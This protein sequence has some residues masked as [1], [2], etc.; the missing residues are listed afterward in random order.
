MRVTEPSTRD[1]DTSTTKPPLLIADAR[2][3][4]AQAIARTL[5]LDVVNDTV[6]FS[7]DAD[8]GSGTGKDAA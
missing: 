4:L 3:R 7:D 8:T 6:M 1:T 5:R 2:E